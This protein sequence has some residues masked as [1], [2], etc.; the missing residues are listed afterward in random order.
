MLK[1]FLIINVFIFIAIFPNIAIGGG[2]MKL[3]SPA[4]EHNKSIPKKYTCQGEDVS[5][6]LKIEGIPQ[7]AK[8]LAI[9]VDDPD[10]PGGM[11]VHWVVFNVPAVNKIEEKAVPGIQG[12]NDFGKNDYGGPCPPSGTH[13]YFHKIY[14]LDT[15]LNLKVGAKK[16]DVEKAMQGHIL[17]KT[18]LI[19]LYKKTG[20]ALW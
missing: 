6:P 9:I 16:S 7:G 10:A 12:F 13:R 8:S 2:T 15:T 3:T 11:W 18:E 1:R 17:D 4:F 5:P 14:A 19:G 20:T